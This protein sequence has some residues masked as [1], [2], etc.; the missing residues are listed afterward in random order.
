[1]SE[2]TLK[3]LQDADFKNDI[4]E[5]GKKIFANKYTEIIVF[6]LVGIILIAVATAIVSSYVRQPVSAIQPTTG[7]Q[8]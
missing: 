1:M 3:E 6:G 7:E 2:K 8:N 4:L 5:S